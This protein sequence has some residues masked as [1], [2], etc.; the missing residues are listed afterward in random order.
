MANG[1][2]PAI[3]CVLDGLGLNYRKK[4]NAVFLARTP[5]LDELMASY[6]FATLG[7]SGED[8]GLVEGQMG[9]SNVGHLN[10]GAGR[11]VYQDLV[12]ID[13]AIRTGVFFDS[14]PL[15]EAMAVAGRPGVTLHLMGLCSP[16]GVHSH[17]RHLYAILDLAVRRG[18]SRVVVHAFLDG[19]DVPP[20][21]AGEYLE[22]LERE[23]ARRGVGRV[24]TVSG[25]YYAMDRDKRWERTAEAYR[26]IVRGEGHTAHS[27]SEALQAAYDRQE[28]DEFVHPTVIVDERGRPVAP[29]RDG[30]A[31]IYFNFRADRAR[32]LTR[33]FIDGEFGGFDRDAPP[34]VHFLAMTQY[35]ESFAI[36]HIFDPQRLDHTMGDLVSSHG[37]KQLRLAETEKYAHVTFFFNG[38]EEQVFPGEDRRMIPS[39]KVAT[40]DLQPAMSAYQVTEVAERAIRSHQYGLI[41]MNFA[42]PDMVGHTGVLQAAVRAVEVVDEC[43]GRVAKAAVEVRTPLLVVADHGNCDQMIDYRTGE[44]HTNHTLNPVPALLVSEA[45]R[46]RRMRSGV[47]ADVSPTLCDLMGLPKPAEMTGRS[48]LEQEKQGG[49]ALD[50]DNQLYR[51]GDP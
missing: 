24:A 21:S 18:L 28:T 23:M 6:P 1:F 25:R 14:Q 44:P 15:N 45:H 51:A 48:L 29:V 41:V 33:A 17:Q 30:D 12:R 50:D 43:V 49:K 37:L 36:P 5:N 9:D 13:K 31:V 35:D 8:V 10:L 26:A 40:Y 34:A 16:G 2:G 39:P 7:A 11:V 27:A 19:R 46:N 32:Q 38:G 47:L 42:N 20:T 22:E 4:G 3:L